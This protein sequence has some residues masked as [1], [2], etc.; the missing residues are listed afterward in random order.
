MSMIEHQC[1]IVRLYSTSQN[2]NSV[3]LHKNQEYIRKHYEPKLAKIKNNRPKTNHCI[4]PLVDDFSKCLTV[5]SKDKFLLAILP[6]FSFQ[7]SF[8]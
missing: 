8:F 6:V 2:N 5:G 3:T 4:I 7:N 1:M